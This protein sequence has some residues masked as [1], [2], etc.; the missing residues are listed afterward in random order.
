MKLFEKQIWHFLVLLL[1]LIGV[2]YYIQLDKSLL[3]GSLWNIETKTWL[4]FAI[5]VPIM[6]QVYVLICWRLELHYNLLSNKF[7]KNAFKIYAIGFF[8]LFASRM[9]FIIFLAESNKETFHINPILKYAILSIVS[10]L[11]LYAFYSVKVY[12][13]MDRAAGLDHF[14]LEVRKLPFVNKGI[15]KYTNNGMYIFAFLII[16]VPS[17]LYQSRAAFIVAIFSHIYIWVHYYC[18]ELPDIKIIYSEVNN[19]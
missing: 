10:F 6:H 16:Y 4:I 5:A 17:I 18:T 9:V 13:G 15:F 8:V 12:F 14:D 7:G 19:N 1:L 3:V 11:A 2:Y